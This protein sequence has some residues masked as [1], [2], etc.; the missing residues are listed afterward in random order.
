MKQLITPIA[1]VA[2]VALSSCSNDHVLHDYTINEKDPIEIS[3]SI[4]GVDVLTKAAPDVYG[5][6]SSKHFDEG[7]KVNVYIFEHKAEGQ[8]T[9]SYTYGVNGKVVYTSDAN[10]VLKA[11][12]TNY[13]PGNGHGID[14]YGIYPISIEAKNESQTFTVSTN[15]STGEDNKNTNYKTS[16]LMFAAK[17][18]IEDRKTA[19]TLTFKHQLSKVI[20]KLV[21]GNGLT[22]NDLDGAEVTIQNTKPECT[23]SS[24]S[25]NGMTGITAS[26]SGTTEDITVGTWDN[27]T[28]S[29]GLAA[30]VVPQDITAGTEL[31][32]IELNN[33]A[34]Y[35]YKTKS[36]EN[37]F[38]G[39]ISGKQHTFT[40]TL[41][42]FGITVNAV[43]SDWEEG[44]GDNG[45][46]TL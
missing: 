42:T 27:E 44:T 13:F 12:P 29:S 19:L 33:G 8:S 21:K 14:I 5:G 9:A 30:I 1:C 23:I 10:G 34:T 38:T 17:Q 46:A 36:D 26:A 24:V 31:I 3:T 4:G 16:D 35:I 37:Q 43:I 15:Q 6:E 28:T 20:V 18:T 41:S 11:D 7:T 22:D 45:S 25:E 40:L 32:K 2:L 39:F